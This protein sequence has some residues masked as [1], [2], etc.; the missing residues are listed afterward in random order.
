[1]PEQRDM[2]QGQASTK[3]NNILLDVIVFDDRSRFKPSNETSESNRH[4][5]QQIFSKTLTFLA[6]NQARTFRAT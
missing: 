1:M 2:H 3:T 4:G 6:R 5:P